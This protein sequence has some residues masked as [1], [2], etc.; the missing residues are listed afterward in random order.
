MGAIANDG[1]LM[2]PQLVRRVYD[3]N[4]EI[5]KTFA[6]IIRRQVIKKQ[7][8]QKMR[9]LLTHSSSSK[10]YIPR[11]SVAG[12]TGTSQKIVNGQYSHTQHISSFSGFFPSKSPRIQVTIVVDSPQSKGIAYGSQNSSPI[13]K[14][15]AEGIIAYMGIPPQPQLS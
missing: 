2:Y 3:A 8:A 15:I 11:Y 1:Q 6:P 14:E 5:I 9:Q 13:F 4:G 12:K 7:T 10:A